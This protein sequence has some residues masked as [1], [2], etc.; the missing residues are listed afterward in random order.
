MIHINLDLGNLPSVLAALSSPSIAQRV[1]SAAAESYNDDVH[2]WIDAG[3]GF[4]PQ[5][6]HLQQAVNWRPVGNGAAEV[7]IRDQTFRNYNQKLD[8]AFDAN[9]AGYAWFVEKG[10]RAHADPIT[11]KAGRKGLKIPVSGGDGYIIR[12]SVKN[13]PGN[14]PYPFFYADQAGRSQRM[15]ARAL[16]VLASAMG[17]GQ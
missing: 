8:Y 6:G 2:D 13:H 5:Y 12:R 9:P 14:R 1:A 15:Q 10:T 11:P 7:Y 17:S 4:T 3:R 16:S